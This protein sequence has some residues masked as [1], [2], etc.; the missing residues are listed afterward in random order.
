M[1]LEGIGNNGNIG[2]KDFSELVDDGLLESTLFSLI[3]SADKGN[4]FKITDGTT[5]LGISVQVHQYPLCN[6]A[7][8]IDRYP[9]DSFL[10]VYDN[11]EGA[12]Q[13]VN[14]S[15]VIHSVQIKNLVAAYIAKEDEILNK[16]NIA[17]SQGIQLNSSADCMQ[18]V[19]FAGVKIQ[20]VLKRTHKGVGIQFLYE[21]SPTVAIKLKDDKRF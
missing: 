14:G 18:P 5:E 4:K 2:Q 6:I 21:I 11:R 13:S 19:V 15:A 10:H 20:P 9:D 17:S 1:G 8:Y 3:K 16:I 12:R 7:V